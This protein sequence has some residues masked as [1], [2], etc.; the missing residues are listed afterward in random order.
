MNLL[1]LGLSLRQDHWSQ[2]EAHVSEGA[3]EEACG[4][5]AG[6]GNTAQLVIPITN[7]LHSPSR[8]RMD[9]QEELNAFY[10]AEE[11]GF[12]VLSVYHSHPNG[13]G[14]P[15]PVDF[16]ELSFPG[17]IYLIWYKQ[18]GQWV[19]RGFLMNTSQNA[20]EVPVTIVPR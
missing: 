14:E 6:E 3:P 16:S 9:P 4:I 13:P 17:I 15:S 7:I 20:I 8:F 12:E 18:G 19:C 5:V 11:K 10:S 2:M 1:R